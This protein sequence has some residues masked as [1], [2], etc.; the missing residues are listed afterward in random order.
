[1]GMDVCWGA[2]P[3][4]DCDF[5]CDL[6]DNGNIVEGKSRNPLDKTGQMKI[7]ID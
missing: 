2:R 3:E 4:R 6:V 5:N 7:L 1:M